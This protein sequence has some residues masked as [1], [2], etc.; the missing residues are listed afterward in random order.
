MS[1]SSVIIQGKLLIKPQ[2]DY[3]NE[4]KISDIMELVNG[5]SKTKRVTR[6]LHKIKEE[7]EYN[8]DD[9][10]INGYYYYP[11]NDF[12]NFGQTKDKSVININRPP[13][14]AP[15]LWLDF[16]VIKEENK[17]F[18]TWN[19]EKEN[20]EVIEQISWLISLIDNVFNPVKMSLNGNIKI[21]DEINK[22][23]T[24]LE[25]RNNEI[26][27]NN[28]IFYY[29]DK[30]NLMAKDFFRNIIEK[31]KKKIKIEKKEILNNNFEL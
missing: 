15:S 10:N 9:Y 27:R 14:R 8:P 26:F 7:L 6:D 20:N 22:S 29:S 23:E 4:V 11:K 24:L 17:H 2:E 25:I 1:S 16:E 18:L 19:G 12:E 31:N 5:M 13:M 3:K 28:K 21:I 30:K